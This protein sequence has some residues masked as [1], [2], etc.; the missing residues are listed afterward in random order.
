MEDEQDCRK[1]FMNRQEER[2]SEGGAGCLP[3]VEPNMAAAGASF[4]SREGVSNARQRKGRRPAAAA[5][6]L[7][8][9]G[10]RGRSSVR[11]GDATRFGCA[12]VF[13]WTMGPSQWTA[14]SDLAYFQRCSVLP[15]PRFLAQA[16]GSLA[17]SLAI[18][19]GQQRLTRRCPTV[20][21][22]LSRYVSFLLYLFLFF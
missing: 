20:H 19:L 16:Q 22:P 12:F 5:A 21:G 18:G 4:Y 11:G 1:F 3:L 7:S 14:A 15:A 13:Q 6:A 2:E 10:R 9:G 8:C 17:Q